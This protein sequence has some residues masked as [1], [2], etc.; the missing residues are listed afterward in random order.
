MEGQS[1]AMYGKP[2]WFVVRNIKEIFSYKLTFFFSVWAYKVQ[3]LD[4][5]HTTRYYTLLLLPSLHVLLYF[6]NTHLPKSRPAW[7]IDCGLK[8]S[9]I[10]CSGFSSFK[11]TLQEKDVL[12]RKLM[13]SIYYFLLSSVEFILKKSSSWSGVKKR[14]WLALKFFCKFIALKEGKKDICSQKIHKSWWYCYKEVGN[15]CRIKLTLLKWHDVF[16]DRGILLLSFLSF[17]MIEFPLCS[18]ASKKYELFSP[19]PVFLP[20]FILFPSICCLL[21]LKVVATFV[22]RIHLL[23]SVA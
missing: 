14:S 13:Y 6:L 22:E 1:A 5:A 23:L 7:W 12:T 21:L 10:P 2:V 16:P 4:Y 18:P 3:R 20:H 11:R 15:H 17:L 9:H 19:V 8:Y